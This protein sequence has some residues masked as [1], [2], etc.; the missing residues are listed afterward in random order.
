M[1]GLLVVNMGGKMSIIK[2]FSVGNGDMFYIN[3]NT[4]NFTIIDCSYDDDEEKNKIFKEIKEKA[5]QKGMRRFISTHPD[6]DHIKGLKEFEETVGVWNFYCV[7]NKAIK[8]DETDDFEK[9]CELR[10]G[11]KHFYLFK[12]CQRKWMNQNDEVRKGAG[13]KCLWPVTSNEEFKI[14]L[15]EAE[16]GKSPNNLSPIITYTVADGVKAMWMGD[17]ESDFLNKVK[18]SI[19][20]EEISILF[21]PHHGRQSGK[22]SD[23]ILKVLNPK[24]VIIGEAPSEYLN[25]YCNYNTISQNTAGEITLDC[26][27]KKIHVYVSSGSY[28]ANFLKNERMPNDSYGRYI[29]T[30]EV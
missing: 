28:T 14:A 30:L 9:Y 2:S 16:E 25:Y 18:D 29:G 1:F 6:D 3:H 7:K 19:E 12:G 11:N 15:K 4:D 17:I 27:G 13:L 10:D 20:F 22:I 5:K 21:A 26:D 24:I 8:N 23:D